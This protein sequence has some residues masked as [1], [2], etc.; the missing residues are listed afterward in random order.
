MAEKQ[1]GAG[2]RSWWGIHRLTQM[3]DRAD[4]QFNIAAAGGL[5][6]DFQCL[7]DSAKNGAGED[8]PLRHFLKTR[9]KR[10][11]MAG[12]IAAVHRGNVERPKSVQRARVVPVI[13]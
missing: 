13:E 12:E 1:V 4:D 2:N 6:G 11:E 9:G 10:Q 5:N 3:T 8:S 7:A